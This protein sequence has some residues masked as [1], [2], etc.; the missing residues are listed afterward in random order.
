MAGD[1]DQ[2]DA[3]FVADQVCTWTEDDIWDPGLF[4]TSCG[5][6]FL[7]ANDDSPEKNDFNFCT[8]CGKRLV[9]RKTPRE[10]EDGGESETA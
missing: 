5:K 2:S 8:Y 10:E 4:S 1:F 6:E 9:S 3:D 7:M